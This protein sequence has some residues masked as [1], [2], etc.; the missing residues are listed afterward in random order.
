M[1]LDLEALNRYVLATI[2]LFAAALYFGVLYVG[3]VEFRTRMR[4]SNGRKNRF[5]K[6]LTAPRLRSPKVSRN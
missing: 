5:R 3:F 4:T 6:R 1:H 2:G